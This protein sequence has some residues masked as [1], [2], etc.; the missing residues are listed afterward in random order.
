MTD[1]G[2]IYS[3]ANRPTVAPE[4]PMDAYGKAL[5]IQNMGQQVQQGQMQTQQMQQQLQDAQEL[6]DTI[7]QASAA[8]QNPIQA[9]AKLGSP[10][11]QNWMKQYTEMSMNQTKLSKEQFD[12]A[13]AHLSKVGGDI[14]TASQQPGATPQAV[15]QLIASHMH[16]GNIPPEQAQQLISSLPQDPTQLPT[17]GM[18]Q[19]AQLG[20]SKDLLSMF[21]PAVHMV[22]TGTATQPVGITAATGK[23][24]NIGAPID[25]SPGASEI[26]KELQDYNNSL[27]GDQEVGVNDP[28]FIKWHN[29]MHPKAFMQPAPGGFGGSGTPGGTPGAGASAP[30]TPGQG[31]DLSALPANVRNTIQALG[32]YRTPP[33]QALP[34]GKEKMAYVN[35]LHQYY[36]G[37]NENDAEEAHKWIKGLAD[38]SPSSVGGQVQTINNVGEHMG[39]MLDASQNIGGYDGVAGVANTPIMAA[40][41]AAKDVDLINWDNGV[42]YLQG[43][44]AKLIKAGLT[45]EGELNSMIHD[46]DAAKGPAGRAAALWTAADFMMGK[47]RTFELRNQQIMG[48]QA[49]VD[50]KTGQPLGLMTPLAQQNFARAFQAAGKEAP[51]FNPPAS[52][53]GNTRTA[54]ANRWNPGTVQPAGQPTAPVQP[55]ASAVPNLTNFHTNP[56]TGQ[57]IGQN[58]SGAWV[59]AATGKPV[60]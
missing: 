47:I 53:L 58:A 25:K 7:K 50:P 42:K 4:N 24:Q 3:M 16:Q 43:E 20:A 49:P 55:Q 10:S 36:P 56:Q 30:A 23:V 60:Q 54:M 11:A 48:N 31:P 21:T 38:N 33:S 44:G 19:G 8:G 12:L 32:E 46:L 37:W 17:W 9:V 34:R 2:S 29:Q 52:P 5:S 14:I 45:T 27:P 57:R 13:N 22:D 35:A 59:D 40:K 26:T 15:G 18:A 51:Q 28:G 1:F 39:I 41:R 6:R